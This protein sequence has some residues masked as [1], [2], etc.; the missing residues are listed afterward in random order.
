MKEAAQRAEQQFNEQKA[1]CM[2]AT[3]LQIVPWKKAI[4]SMDEG[5]DELSDIEPASPLSGACP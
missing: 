4:K 1:Q 2:H 3:G 5:V